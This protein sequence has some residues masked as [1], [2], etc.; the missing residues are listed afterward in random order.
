MNRSRTTARGLVCLALVALLSPA[1]LA[2]Q[3]L[4]VGNDKVGGGVAQYTL[5]ITGASTPNFT[6]SS[7]SVIS[8]A[9]DA[10][11]D[12]AVG[13]LGG[14]LKVFTAPL[15]GA[16][17]ASASFHNGASSGAYALAFNPAGDLFAVFSLG[18]A[19]VNKFA[20]P[21][22]NASVPSQTITAAGLTQPFGVAFDAAQ[23]LYVSNAGAAGGNLFVFEP[24]YTEARIITPVVAGALYRKIAV[25]GTHLYACA[26]GPGTGRI[27][28]YTLPITASSVP[29]YTITTGTNIPETVVVDSIGRLYV[30]NLGNSTVT[31]YNPPFSAASAP[32]TSLLVG[33]GTFAIFGM[34]TESSCSSNTA[35]CLGGGR[36][37]VQASWQSS[38]AA[39]QGTAVPLTPD[40]GYFWF[41]N[42]ANVEL[43]VK[44]LD[45]CPVNARKWVFGGGL[46]NVATTI[47]VTDLQTGSV[48]VYLNPLNT[49]FQPLQD[50]SAFSTCP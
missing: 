6:V 15:S 3:H 49:P 9:V 16:S 25:D 41:F 45:G 42:P 11:G 26:A 19:G 31:V 7:D 38:T 24:P 28:V 44:V 50:S 5:P 34:A 32:T 33:G 29:A 14:N 30:G 8:V 1:V 23:N 43:V 18:A 10:N 37:L 46:T 40:T 12:M 47:T 20:H 13:D 35:L 36:F 27:D 17:T 48:R 22:S 21:F 4:Y 2:A 39:G